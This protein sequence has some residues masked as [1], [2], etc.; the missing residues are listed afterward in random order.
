[1]LV[2]CGSTADRPPAAILTRAPD[3]GEQQ[4]CGAAP[5][6]SSSSDPP[7]L[8]ANAVT[9]KGRVLDPGGM[10]PLYDVS[11]YSP[12][13]GAALPPIKKG[14]SCDRC[15]TTTLNPLTSALTDASGTF[16]LTNVPV[17]MTSIVVQIGKWRRVTT[18][19]VTSGCTDIG[20]F[21]L[22][23]K[24]SE[25]DMPQIAVTTG[26]ADSLECLLELMGI[27]PSEFVPGPGGAGHI[28]MFNGLLGKGV[29]GSPEASTL[30]NDAKALAAYDIVLLSCE[31]EEA[32]DTKTNKQAMH[33]YVEAGGRVFASHYQYTWFKNGPNDDFKNVADWGGM[34]TAPNGITYLVVQDFPKGKA[35]AQWLFDVHASPKVGEIPLVDVRESLSTVNTKT[36]Q[37]WL[38]DGPGNVKYFSFNAPIAAASK[39]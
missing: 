4:R 29:T 12:R 35:F 32:N 13:S 20:D 15:G 21:R 11:V 6:S 28:H 39:T 34:P 14:V 30:W 31:G 27:D 8:I 36:S 17:G 10:N 33:D 25:G 1:M 9:V 18:V 26:G 23:S 5:A 19:N 16:V 24:S 22:P 38:G 2:A 7:D 3:A 37:A